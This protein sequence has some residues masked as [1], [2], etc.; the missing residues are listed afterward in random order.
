RPR[1]CGAP[2][3]K[4]S[5]RPRPS[6]AAASAPPGPADRDARAPPPSPPHPPL[7]PPRTPPPGTPPGP[8]PSRTA[9]DERSR[10][11]I[12]VVLFDRFTA[13]DAVGPYE[14]LSRIPGA[15]TVF[16]AERAG[17][18]RDESGRLALTAD[19]T[20]D[21]VPRPDVVVTPGGPGQSARMTDAT[22]LD[23]LRTADATSTWTTS[24][25]SG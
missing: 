6:T 14:I 8:A 10:M 2:S 24:V 13:L 4:R 17:P 25:C 20:L 18:V 19:R 15:E 16:V 22:L 1:P 12:A 11:Q 7:H 3:S 21:E 5:A 9:L 23:W